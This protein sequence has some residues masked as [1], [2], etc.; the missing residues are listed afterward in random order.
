MHA[1]DIDSRRNPDGSID[2]RFMSDLDVVEVSLAAGA[3]QHLMAAAMATATPDLV[4]K[5]DG[6]RLNRIEGRP[7]IQF[8]FGE[9]IWLTLAVAPSALAT[10]LP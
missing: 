6:V 5:P 1:T 4:L 7:V 8:R 2:L 3:G 9:D 10:L